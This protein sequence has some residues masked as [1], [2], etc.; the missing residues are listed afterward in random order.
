MYISCMIYIIYIYINMYKTY[1][2]IYVGVM[3]P[4]SFLKQFVAKWNIL[5][6]P[7]DDLEFIYS[8]S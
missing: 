4:L 8:I 2:K 6:S 5:S 7:L 1:W 3:F